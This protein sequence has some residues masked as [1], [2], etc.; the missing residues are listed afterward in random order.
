MNKEA[1]ARKLAF[2]VTD[3]LFV[4]EKLKVGQADEAKQEKLVDDQTCVFNEVF[5]AVDIFLEDQEEPLS[6]EVKDDAKDLALTVAQ[7]A[8]KRKRR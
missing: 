4:K 7:T 8:V 3:N 1:F 6:A 2:C 5:D